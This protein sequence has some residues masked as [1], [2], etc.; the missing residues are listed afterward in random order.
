[1]KYD[2]PEA[3]KKSQDL[4][5]FTIVSNWLAWR[6]VVYMAYMVYMANARVSWKEIDNPW[7]FTNV[8][9][10]ES[11]VCPMPDSSKQGNTPYPNGWKKLL[12]F[13]QSFKKNIH[14][15]N[16]LGLGLLPLLVELPAWQGL[17]LLLSPG[18][19]HHYY[20]YFHHHHHDMAEL[21]AHLCRESIRVG[22]SGQSPF[23]EQVS[24]I[25]VVIT[26]S[27][28]TLPLLEG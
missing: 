5:V 14:I 6:W 20:Q 19:E 11:I 24:A 13:L 26:F 25:K 2:F 23:G 7:Q 12:S 3:D 10:V 8:S 17:C 21:S 22:Q 4:R 15:E 1:M 28:Q 18:G 16:H 9:N 27:L